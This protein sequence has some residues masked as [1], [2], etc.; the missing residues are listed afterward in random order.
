MHLSCIPKFGQGTKEM[1]LEEETFEKFGYYP[2]DL[3]HG[4][5]KEILVSCDICGDIRIV[6]QWNYFKSKTKFC[7]SCAL[8]AS[9]PNFKGSNHPR[10]GQR[11]YRCEQCGRIID[12]CRKHIERKKHRFCSVKCRGEWQRK[13]IIRICQ[14]CGKEI[15]IERSRIRNDY[16]N[17]CSTE[18][19]GKWQSKYLKG[20]NNPNW[21]GGEI[22]KICPVCGKE[23]YTKSSPSRIKTGRGKYCSVLC[24]RK[25]QR[26]PKHH[27]KPELIFEQI[28]KNNNLPFKYTGNGIF[29]IHNINPDFV[30]CNGKKIAVEVFGDYWHSPLLNY[31]LKEDRTLSYRKK[32]LKKYGWKLIVFWESDLLRK[33]VE[34][35]VLNTIKK[36]L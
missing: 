8:K 24:R 16:G 25:A 22:K 31:K 1:I 34:A 5:H 19:M 20:E 6:T 17:F 4:S 35:F 15:Y 23:F 32:T 29:W 9:H 33:D 12:R 28:C 27:T 21:K 7:R 18:C 13:G 30:D 10:W 36:K 2:S 14:Y 26:M 3:S 11:I